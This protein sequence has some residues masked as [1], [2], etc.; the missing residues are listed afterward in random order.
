MSL[1]TW[2]HAQHS[3]WKPRKEY[4]NTNTPWQED[5]VTQ[6]LMNTR[7]RNWGESKSAREWTQREEAR[8]TRI[9]LLFTQFRLTSSDE[10]YCAAKRITDAKRNI[11]QSPNQVTFVFILNIRPVPRCLF[12]GPLAQAA[13]Y[14]WLARDIGWLQP[15][16]RS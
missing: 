3:G 11:A 1:W 10:P 4:D 6:H 15:W 16:Y 12:P 9:K 14:S 2:H 7:R 13:L 5:I 8:L